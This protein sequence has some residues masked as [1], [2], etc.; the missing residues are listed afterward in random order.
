MCNK[1]VDNYSD[2]LQLI[3]ECCKTQKMCDKAFNT[4]LSTLKLFLNVL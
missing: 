4:Q 3:S 2:M 1:A